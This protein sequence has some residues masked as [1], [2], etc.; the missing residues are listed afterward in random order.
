[1]EI[2][3]LPKITLPISSSSLPTFSFSSPVITTSPSSISPAQSLTN[4][5][6]NHCTNRGGY[7]CYL[8]KKK[9]NIQ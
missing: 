2:P 7:C 8:K 5:V 3:V 9:S 1:M 4:K 6:P